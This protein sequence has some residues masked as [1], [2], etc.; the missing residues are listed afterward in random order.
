MDTPPRRSWGIARL[1]FS[2]GGR[3]PP[4]EYQAFWRLL[5][6]GES[7]RRVFAN[8][9]KAGRF[10]DV[11]AA[12]SP[13][14]DGA[15]E[16]IT[17]FLAIQRDVTERREAEEARRFEH[18]VLKTEQD[19]TPDGILVVDDRARILSFNR[20]FAEM[21]GIPPD[22]VEARA[23]EAV[24]AAVTTKVADPERFLARV[25]ELYDRH[26]EVSSDEVALRDGRTF[27]R[28]SAPMRDADGRYYGRVWYF[29]DITGRKEAA[30]ALRSE[31]D[32]AEQYL[33]LVDVILLGLDL[34][35]HVTMINRKGCAVLERKAPEILGQVWVET[36]V[37]ERIRDE[38]TEKLQNV[39]LG[40]VSDL[41]APV[42]TRSGEE[43]MIVW[44][45][46]VVRD[47]A[48][49]VVGTLSSGEDVTERRRTE[50]ALGESQ[51]H[52]QLISDNVLDLVSEIRSD[53]TF[54][55]VSPSYEAVL[56]Y[57]PDTLLGTS[58]F[59][60][61]HPSDLERVQRILRENLRRRTANRTDLRYRRADGTYL[62]LEVV[63]KPLFDLDGAPRG[64][65]LSGRDITERKRGEAAQRE[66]DRRLRVAMSS[67]NL[68]VFT[69][70]DHLRYTW[71]YNPH[72]FSSE[73]DALGHT[74][75]ELVPTSFSEQTTR[76]KT[77]ALETGER[78]REEISGEVEG[79]TRSFEVTVEPLKDEHGATQGVIGASLETT[80]R[81]QLEAE[82]RQAQKL[83]AIGS[84]AGGIAHDFNNLL[85]AILG[86]ADL[87]L[88]ELDPQSAARADIEE[89]VRA[90]R[91]AE[92]LTRQLLI[93]SRK[94][95]VRNV[96]LRLNDVV[97]HLEKILDR[98]VGAQV[99]FSVT[100]GPSTG[101][102]MGDVGQIEQ[103]LMNLVVNAR[104]AMPNGGSLVVETGEAELDEA[105]ARAHGGTSTG[106]FSWLTVRDS[107]IG[108]TPEVQAKLFDPF[109]TTKG[110]E[111]G[112][113]LGLVTVR[114]IVQRSNGYIVVRS[115][116]G[117]GSA[118]T[119]HFPRVVGEGEAAPLET[120]TAGV[121]R[122]TETILFV[123]SDASIRSLVVKALTQQGYKVWPARD[124]REA[125]AL[126]EREPGTLDIVVTTVVMPATSGV[127]LA[128]QMRQK[129]AGVKVLY[130]S[131]FTDDAE[132]VRDIRS[133]G[134][135]FIAKPYTMESLARAIRQV[136]DGS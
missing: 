1:G 108:M 119:V 91:S 31:R 33:D 55:Y 21:W 50:E 19:L 22:L 28:H 86:Y 89:V 36:F 16:S 53:G 87:A 84:L 78:V 7:V 93:F 71:L 74:D 135:P 96:R 58:A 15:H 72:L 46:T 132:L 128:T 98:V 94:S 40:D 133:G 97:A 5:L 109:F 113:G 125:L 67:V 88:E 124:A 52:L 99:Q 24:L 34:E 13:I 35:G 29:R 62:W 41:V 59:A 64:A 100:L 8:R 25:R 42:L 92:S 45:N 120:E 101:F 17:G 114:T 136:L 82:F 95:I 69:Q 118:F 83:E 38:V 131:G 112:T 121:P 2:G 107:G 76:L 75:L 127:D 12:V 116:P 23:D 111:K 134:L 81:H 54:V 11:E 20:Q 3:V 27:E 122:G 106:P 39:R 10:V 66:F 85:T 123:N 70:D 6:A 73:S 103:I 68:F 30:V 77:R 80:A 60:L 115:A 129:R 26:E 57:R 102:I 4:E 79:R 48:R 61:V 18:A 126:A 47:G 110:P 104:D 51:T 9:T 43:R 65:V 14:W 117:R 56:G 63:G 90:G 105:F 44:R 49:L 32:R 37:P 130:T